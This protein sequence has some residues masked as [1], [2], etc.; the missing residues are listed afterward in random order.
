MRQLITLKD[1]NKEIIGRW[2]IQLNEENEHADII[3]GSND[4]FWLEKRIAFVGQL[5]IIGRGFLK[6]EYKKEALIVLN[7]LYYCHGIFTR[8]E[9]VLW[10]NSCLPIYDEVN[11][12]RFYRLL[13]NK[14]ID[15]LTVKLKN[16]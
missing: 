16:M 15:W 5:D 7:G 8:E 3:Y 14:E 10:F 11:D 2:I 9:F 12:K 4:D 1:I 6:E 13:T